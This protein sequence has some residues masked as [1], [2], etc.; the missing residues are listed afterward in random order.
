M[1]KFVGLLLITLL[2]PGLL[3]GAQSATCSYVQHASGQCPSTSGTITDG[4]VDLEASSTNPGSG[5][6]G[7]GG[8][9]GN[10]T[11]GPATPPPDPSIVGYQPDGTPI[12]RGVFTVTAPVTLRDIAHFRPAPGSQA[13]E[14]DGWMVVGLPTNFFAVAPQ[15]ILHGTLLDRAAN[16]RFTPVR[17][18]WTYGDGGSATV[19]T[20][21]STWAAAGLREFASTATSH[22]YTVAG[23]YVIDL[24]IDYRA[25]Y[26][27]DEGAWVPIA[28]TIA[29]PANPLRAT[30]GSAQTVLVD[31]DC[32]S[33]PG[34]PGC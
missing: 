20:P 10:G 28:G 34:G 7:T 25:E 15:Q 13:M 26:R 3:P 17:Y 31:R 30:A 4:Q 21:G 29:L 5:N 6:P 8:N 2:I 14:P 27:Y 11:G 18:R 9:S 23:S 12:I 33:R 32:A 24:I 1:V 19:A 16:V 22:R